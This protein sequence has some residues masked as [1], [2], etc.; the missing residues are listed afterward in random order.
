ML[1]KTF[2]WYGIRRAFPEDVLLATEQLLTNRLPYTRPGAD[3][4]DGA[5][6]LEHRADGSS[7]WLTNDGDGFFFVVR[8]PLDPATGDYPDSWTEDRLCDSDRPG[9]VR[10]WLRAGCPI[11]LT[12]RAPRA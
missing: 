5:W 1:H 4:A 3:W 8:P 9:R 2:D 12:V 11:P 7:L 10:Q 6:L